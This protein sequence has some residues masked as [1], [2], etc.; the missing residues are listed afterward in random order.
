MFNH[1]HFPTLI[2]LGIIITL[3]AL[4]FNL[5]DI[6]QKSKQMTGYAISE[7]P[8]VQNIFKDIDLKAFVEDRLVFNSETPS[9]IYNSII[10]FIFLSASITLIRFIYKAQA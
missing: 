1:K 4:T 10:V 6:L 9:K 8:R 3:L 5:M 7:Q 2:Y